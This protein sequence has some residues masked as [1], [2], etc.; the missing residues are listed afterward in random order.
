MAT[1]LAAAGMNPVEM[2]RVF[3]TFNAWA[4]PFRS[5]P[6]PDPVVRGD[7]AENPEVRP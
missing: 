3:H 7:R 5:V 2:D 6:L 4:E 1:A